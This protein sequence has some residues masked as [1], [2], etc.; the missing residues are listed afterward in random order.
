MICVTILNGCH[1][2]LYFRRDGKPVFPG[3]EQLSLL[4]N[5]VSPKVTQSMNGKCIN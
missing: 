5:N 4:N 2:L 3:E 1:Y